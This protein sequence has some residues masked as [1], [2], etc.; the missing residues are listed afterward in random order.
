MVV[1]ADSLFQW[2][3][4]S[5]TRHI[6]KY[7]VLKI[8]HRAVTKIF[9]RTRLISLLFTIINCLYGYFQHLTIWAILCGRHDM[10]LYFLSLSRQPIYLAIVCASLYRCMA[11]YVADYRTR[12]VE[13]LRENADAFETLGRGILDVT[14]A[15]CPA[16]HCHLTFCPYFCTNLDV[17]LARHHHWDQFQRNWGIQ[18][19]PTSP[20]MQERAPNLKICSTSSLSLQCAKHYWKNSVTVDLA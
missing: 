20:K 8:F 6:C 13:T 14:A 9:G 18:P 4:F 12:V 17:Q 3:P 7:N 5:V 16:S 19:V 10:A 1:K 2:S 11:S 15:K